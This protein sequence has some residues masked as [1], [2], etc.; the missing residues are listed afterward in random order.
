VYIQ[1]IHYTVWYRNTT[2]IK[3][4][5]GHRA[6]IGWLSVLW[7]GYRTWWDFGHF[8][9]FKESRLAVGPNHLLI[10]WVK[11]AYRRFGVNLNT[12]LNIVARLTLWR[13]KTYI[14]TSYRTANLQTLHFKYLLDKYTLLN[15]LNPLH[16]LLFSLSLS[17]SLSCRLFHNTAFFGSC[18][19]HI[20][21][22]GCAKI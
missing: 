2:K 6:P 22:I 7:P 11:G 13:L 3:Y 21:N 4:G 1:N 18:N 9:Y 14:Y 8:I 19:I 16:I 15:I 5:F 10:K 20:W 12:H 17:L